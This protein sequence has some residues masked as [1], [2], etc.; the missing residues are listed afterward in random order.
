MKTKLLFAFVLLF[1]IFL[2]GC[3]II[4]FTVGGLADKSN[5][6]K[7]RV[8][9]VEEL[10]TLKSGTN[11]KIIT[12]AGKTHKG[13]YDA[14]ETRMSVENKEDTL[15]RINKMETITKIKTIE[16]AEV[17]QER[18]KGFKFLGVIGIIVDLVVFS[19]ILP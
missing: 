18:V 16:I 17:V 12:K 1:G 9:S 8:I 13:M 14:Y 11:V 10:K 6:K 19:L 7:Y 2:Q 5:N 15:I 3:T 4:G